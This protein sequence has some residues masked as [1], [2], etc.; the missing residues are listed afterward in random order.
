MPRF[1]PRISLLSA[2]LLMTI[3]GMCIVIVQLWR[4]VVPL[5]EEVRSYRNELGFLTID[6][7][8]RIHGIQVPTREDGWKWRVYFPPGGDYKLQCYTGIIPAGIDSSQR[9]DFKLVESR[10]RWILTLIRWHM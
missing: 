2:L 3:V 7:R 8:T 1:R 4:E 6:D 9:R 5:R 10:P